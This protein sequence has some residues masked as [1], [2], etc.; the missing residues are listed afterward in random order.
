MPEKF[1]IRGEKPLKG[2]VEVMGAKNVTF[3]LLAATLLTKE[4]CQISNLP[5][6]EDVFKMLKILERMGAKIKWLGERQIEIS[7]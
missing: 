2:V 4:P 5:L 1:L 6:I 7:V 3:P